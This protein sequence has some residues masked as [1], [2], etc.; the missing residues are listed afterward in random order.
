[1][2]LFP[3]TN[4][5]KV[6]VVMTDI[7]SAVITPMENLLLKIPMGSTPLGRTVLGAAVGSAVAY[8]V[9]PSVSFFDDGSARPFIMTD[10]Q[11]PEA[12]VFPWWGFVVLPAI[13]LGVFL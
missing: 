9:R 6:C 5:T 1:M 3:T 4:V 7:D 12:A 13:T 8:Y 2:L 11:N 10:A